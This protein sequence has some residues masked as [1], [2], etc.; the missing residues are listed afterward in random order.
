VAFFYTLALLCAD[1]KLIDNFSDR[2]MHLNTFRGMF[3]EL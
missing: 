3:S 1:F 2:F